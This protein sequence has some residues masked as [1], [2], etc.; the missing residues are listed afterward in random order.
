MGQDDVIHR[1]LI[2]GLDYLAHL[3]TRIDNNDIPGV[4]RVTDNI[5]IL[6]EAGRYLDLDPFYLHTTSLTRSYIPA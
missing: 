1:P 2:Q 5:T 4:R 6:Y 3:R